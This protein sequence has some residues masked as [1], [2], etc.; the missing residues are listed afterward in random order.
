MSFV[1]I[2]ALQDILY[3]QRSKLNFTL[4]PIF[5]ALFVLKFG[6]EDAH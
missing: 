3:T 6:T 5:F 2:G 4:F 1:R